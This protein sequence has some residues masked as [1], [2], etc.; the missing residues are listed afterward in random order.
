MFDAAAADPAGPGVRALL[1]RADVALRGRTPGVFV[2]T[3]YRPS[4]AWPLAWSGVPSDI[5]VEPV[6]GPE[7]FF[8]APGPLGL[9]LIYVKPVLDPASRHRVGVIVAER[10]VSSSPGIRTIVLEGVLAMPIP[11]PVT[12]QPYSA[13]TAARGFVVGAPNGQPLLVAQVSA[14]SIQ[15]A[16]ES[17]RGRTSAVV[18]GILS[19]TL[20]V[21]M[22]RCCDG[23]SR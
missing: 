16:R 22:P 10:V 14:Q 21:S 23:A 9:R 20:I 13:A 17:W 7:T 18:L 1:D 4:G 6:A 8:L 3:A 5:P 15:D 12:V 19:L 2:V 11:V